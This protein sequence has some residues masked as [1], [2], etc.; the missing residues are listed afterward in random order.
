MKT[1]LK[2]KRPKE[3]HKHA[4]NPIKYSITLLK[5]YYCAAKLGQ[6]HDSHVGST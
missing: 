2:K 4:V 5:P 3:L 1:G 6:H